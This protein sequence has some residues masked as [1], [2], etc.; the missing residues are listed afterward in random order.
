VPERFN[1]LNELLLRLQGARPGGESNLGPV[2]PVDSRYLIKDVGMPDRPPLIVFHDHC[3]D[4]FCA[5]W[6]LR[7]AFPEAELHPANYGADPPDCTDKR[8]IIAD[9]SY[10]RPVMRQILGEAKKVVV[11]DHHKTAA[12]ELAGLVDEFMQ[13]PDLVH[14]PPS[15]ELPEIVFDMT[16]S[17]GRITWDW[18]NDKG[19]L[20]PHLRTLPWLV[21]YT[22][23]RDLWKWALPHSRQINAYLRSYEPTFDQW[24]HWASWYKDGPRWVKM[25][26]DGDA[27]LRTEE[28]IVRAH[29]ERAFEVDFAGWR[30]L[31][32]N[33]TALYSEVG[34]RLAEGR[35]FGLTYFDRADGLRSWS[36]RRG[37]V[38]IDLGKVAAELG[39]GGHPAAAGFETT[40]AVGAAWVEQHRVK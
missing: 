10:K 18:L 27:I 20:P 22:E 16:K 34:N 28:Q 39:G 29:V 40:A 15:S 12:A 23:D 6:L 26:N 37:N 8:V 33:A 30:V 36:L 19:L 9:F 38:D 3:S 32:V 35:P 5:A 7:H 21:E 13:R 25:I 17:G 4:G 11:L 1:D 2:I 24:D 31:C 14:N